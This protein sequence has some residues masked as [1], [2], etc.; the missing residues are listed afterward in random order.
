MRSLC[1]DVIA[2]I[3]ACDTFMT[4]NSIANWNEYFLQTKRQ[5]EEQLNELQNGK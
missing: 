2:R 4:I 1:K 3:K 5:L